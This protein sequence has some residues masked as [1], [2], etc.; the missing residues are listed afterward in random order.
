MNLDYILFNTIVYG[1]VAMIIAWYFGFG[2]ILNFAMGAY[3]IMWWYILSWLAV[4]G[5]S[6]RNICMIVVLFWSYILVNWGLLTYFP[7]DKKRD[8]VWLVLTLWL[9]I[10]LENITNYVYWPN[11]VSLSVTHIPIYVLILI[12]VGLVVFFFYF[13]KYTFWWVT[14]NAISENNKLVRGLG[15]STK[16]ILQI[17]FIIFLLLL[18][19]ATFLVLK[20]SA[21]R[22]SDWI[23]YMI[24]GIWIMIL[25]GITK[26][27]YM[28]FGALIYVLVEYLLFIKLWLPISYKETLILIIILMVLMFKPEWLFALRSRK[29]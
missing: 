3:M 29:I 20:N 2:K 4:D 14:L 10:V 12:F 15:I 5:F 11:S 28:F 18:L 22:A 19:F 23:F 25:V 26:K 9:S 6:L 17:L 1:I 8:H 24:K 21:L 27:E 7:N 13:Y 16:I